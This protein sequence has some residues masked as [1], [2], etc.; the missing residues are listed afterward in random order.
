ML[1]YVHNAYNML[2]YAITCGVK[3]VQRVTKKLAFTLRYIYLH[4]YLLINTCLFVTFCG[5]SNLF[6]SKS[7]SLIII[8]LFV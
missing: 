7:N 1:I 4:N 8:C 2:Q 6:K 3:I 5:F